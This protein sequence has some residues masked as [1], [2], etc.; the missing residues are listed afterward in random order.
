MIKQLILCG[1]LINFLTISH[2]GGAFISSE[3]TTFHQLVDNFAKVDKNNL[4][5]T[6]V[7]KKA[8][9]VPYDY[10]LTQH[11]MT[12][13]IEKYYQRTP[14]IQKI[15][16]TKDEENNIYS[17]IIIML[18]DK[19][20]A[21]NDAEIAQVKKEEVVVGTA[22]IAMNFN[23]LPEKVITGVL[24]SNV[25]L[26]KLL[27]TNRI[28]VVHKDRAYFSIRCNKPLS[29]LTLCKINSTIYGRINTI[30]RAD[31]KR[32]LARVIEILPG[33]TREDLQ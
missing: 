20:Q 19:N 17:R 23:E 7:S 21:R 6:V 25:P 30:I 11:F 32:W 8:L 28:R 5:G 10:L 15:Y 33:V 4:P 14:I 26:G 16:A 13:S 24:T 31:N 18:L 22:V 9:P 2:A 3:T 27:V 1:V 29:A 12:P